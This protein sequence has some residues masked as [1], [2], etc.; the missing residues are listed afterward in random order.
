MIGNNFYINYLNLTVKPFDM[1]KNIITLIVV[2]LISGKI[3]AQES[4]S[5]ISSK[6]KLSLIAGSSL[7]S[8]RD[9]E[10]YSQYGVP[11]IGF[12]GGLGIIKGIT[13]RTS[14]Q[15]KLLFETKGFKTSKKD[16]LNSADGPIIGDLKNNF[17]FNYL[18]LSLA[19]QFSIGKKKAVTLG[20]GFYYSR[21]LNAQWQII[22]TPS[23]SNTS[24]DI[25]GAYYKNDYGISVN[26]GY[27]IEVNKKFIIDFQLTENY[28]L[29]QIGVGIPGYE[30][31]N[32]S[33]VLSV[34]LRKK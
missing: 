28:G 23:N 26:L 7:L 25:M 5:A 4:P 14:I 12:S 3:M 18:T 16:T 30:Q 19:P 33:L 15:G 1:S 9:N 17:H 6:P 11:K 13:P 2:L 27:S 22:Y 32:N 8:V 24:T 20:F 29:R 31:K 10:L 34:G 21:L